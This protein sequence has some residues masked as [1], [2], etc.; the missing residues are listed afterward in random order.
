MIIMILIIVAKADLG[1]ARLRL[2][3]EYSFSVFSMSCFAPPGLSL[4]ELVARI[5]RHKQTDAPYRKLVVR[6]KRYKQ[7]NRQTQPPGGPKFSTKSVTNAGLNC[8]A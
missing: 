3:P 8:P 5:K 1:P 4:V 2:G 6:M 7:T